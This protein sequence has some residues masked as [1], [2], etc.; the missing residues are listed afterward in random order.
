MVH[1]GAEEM[2]AGFFAQG[3]VDDDDD[4]LGEPGEQ[5]TE[6]DM[7]QSIGTPSSTGKESVQ[8]G[9]VFS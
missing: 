3:I 1:G 9:M 7:A 4:V 2:R 8:A 6:Q 5:E